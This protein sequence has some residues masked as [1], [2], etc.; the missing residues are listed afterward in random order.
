MQAISVETISCS[1]ANVLQTENISDKWKFHLKN[2]FKILCAA[3]A[4]MA[5]FAAL[6]RR[7]CIIQLY[8]TSIHDLNNV[9]FGLTLYIPQ[10]FCIFSIL[11]CVI[12][13]NVVFLLL[14][15]FKEKAAEFCWLARIIAVGEAMAHGCLYN[16]SS[17]SY[18]NGCRSREIPIY[19]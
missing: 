13:H 12:S 1:A 19:L 14:T 2:Y 7:I 10:V 5:A 6:D 3:L 15:N 11:I 18:E 9:T 17:I 16:V 4:I 8:I